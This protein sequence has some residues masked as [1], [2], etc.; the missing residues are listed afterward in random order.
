MSSQ[1][2]DYSAV[3]GNHALSLL[4]ENPDGCTGPDIHRQVRKTLASAAL[5]IKRAA[6][7]SGFSE[8]GS[9]RPGA[10]RCEGV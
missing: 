2:S 1:L 9:Q 6:G 7:T 3:T 5:A 8:S 4:A 10:A